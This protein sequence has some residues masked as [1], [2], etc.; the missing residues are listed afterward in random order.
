MAALLWLYALVR[1]V[2]LEF[3]D[4]QQ[5]ITSFY[6]SNTTVNS[7]IAN[8]LVYG[9]YIG[10]NDQWNHLFTYGVSPAQAVAISC[11]ITNVSS[12]SSLA[13]IG[14]S[15]QTQYKCD[16]ERTLANVS[17]TV[18]STQNFSLYWMG[19]TASQCVAVVVD[20]V[21]TTLKCRRTVGKSIR[22]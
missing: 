11:G 18:N 16:G 5:S 13:A 6:V 12:S 19:V 21:T 22:M 10:Y 20:N 4:Q 9:T 8:L 7:P 1:V 15:N 14:Y 2:F 3:D 17:L